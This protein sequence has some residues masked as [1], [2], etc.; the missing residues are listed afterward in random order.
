[1]IP[2][3]FSV[4]L[5]SDDPSRSFRQFMIQARRL[6]SKSDQ[7][8][9]SFKVLD[10]DIDAISQCTYGVS[11]RYLFDKLFDVLNEIHKTGKKTQPLASWF[12]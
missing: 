9:G 10:D 5:T 6:D 7:A 11:A 8:I 3:I 2:F 1:M 4:N 12:R